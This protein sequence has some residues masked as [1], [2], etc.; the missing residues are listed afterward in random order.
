MTNIGTASLETGHIYWT[1]R[2]FS[3]WQPWYPETVNFDDI[4]DPIFYAELLLWQKIQTYLEWKFSAVKRLWFHDDVDPRMKQKASIDTAR[5]EQFIQV[6][7]EQVKQI[8]ELQ[9]IPRTD[10]IIQNEYALIQEALDISIP[11]IVESTSYNDIWRHDAEKNI[12]RWPNT[13]VWKRR[14]QSQI[15]LLWYRNYK[16]IPSCE[17]LDYTFYKK[18]LE[19]STPTMYH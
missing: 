18:R 3:I 11:E 14:K 16:D 5:W 15:R 12:L 19:M 7:P 1:S 9:W 4:Q 17:V 2:P 6:P 8:L 10:L 13:K